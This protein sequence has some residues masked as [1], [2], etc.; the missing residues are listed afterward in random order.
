MMAANLNEARKALC[1]FIWAVYCPSSNT[2][3]DFVQPGIS[4]EAAVAKYGADST[5]W[6]G[7]L[8]HCG[9]SVLGADAPVFIDHGH[10]MDRWAFFAEPN[11]KTLCAT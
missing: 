5:V 2:L 7:G 3:I 9:A 8:P 1:P 10:R 11:G 4:A 6:C